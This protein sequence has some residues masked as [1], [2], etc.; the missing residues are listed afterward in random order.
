[1]SLARKKSKFY[2]K[3]RDGKLALRK[4]MDTYVPEEISGESSRVLVLRMLVGSKERALIWY[5][6]CCL[7]GMQEFMT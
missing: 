5:K 1:M 2:K 6:E 4:M 3:T 7:T